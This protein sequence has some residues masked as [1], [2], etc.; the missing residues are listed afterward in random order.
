MD[1]AIFLDALKKNIEKTV[2]TLGDE[3]KDQLLKTGIGYAKQS[4]TKIEGWIKAAGAGELKPGDLQF[5]LGSEQDLAQME[6]LKEEGL[7][8]VLKDKLK[9]A[10]INSIVDAVFQIIP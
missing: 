5:L 6:F 1:Y 9:N 7:A 8:L 2:E 3:Y 4:K 10:F